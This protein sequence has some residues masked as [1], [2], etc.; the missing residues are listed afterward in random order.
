MEKSVRQIRKEREQ[1]FM[2][3]IHLKPTDRVPVI[4]SI[5]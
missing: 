1:R 3:A 4:S 5:G 2:D